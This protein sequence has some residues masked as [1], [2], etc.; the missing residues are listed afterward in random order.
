MHARTRARICISVHVRLPVNA[1]GP[2]EDAHTL[3][4]EVRSEREH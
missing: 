3:I 4:G 2:D 1:R